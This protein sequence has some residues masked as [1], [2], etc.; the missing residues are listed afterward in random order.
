MQPV[1]QVRTR[2]KLNNDAQCTTQSFSTPSVLCCKL[3]K[4]M[5]DLCSKLQ[6][7]GMIGFNLGDAVSCVYT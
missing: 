3:V 6:L 4:L 5:V 1:S 2:K 7:E